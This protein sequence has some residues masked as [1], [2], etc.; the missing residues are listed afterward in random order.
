MAAHKSIFDTPPDEAEEARLD[1]VAEADIEA[2]HGVPHSQVREWLAK[3][4]KGEK[5]P[6][7]TV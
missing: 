1:H 2:G 7:P 5:V 6:P 4:G 3:R